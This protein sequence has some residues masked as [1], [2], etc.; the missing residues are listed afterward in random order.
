MSLSPA[1]LI[2]ALHAVPPELLLLLQA[3]I[4]FGAI[5]LMARLFGEPGLYLYIL[6][7]VIGANVEVLK[8]VQ[9]GFYDHPVAMGTVLFGSTYLATDI[10]TEHYGRQA[11]RRAVFL[12]FAGYLLF[13]G[14]MLLTLGFRPMTAAQAGTD[15]QWALPMQEH[16]AALF[17]P[18]PALFAAGM[19]SYL[20]SQLFDVWVYQRIRGITGQKHLWLR[21]NGSTMLSSFVDNC[22]FSV[23]AWVVFAPEPVGW[24]ALLHTYILGTYLLRVALSLLDTPFM[25]L[26]R[27]ALAPHLPDRAA[28]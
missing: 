24:D 18:A 6:I 10:L 5:L 20:I 16:I 13:T 3:L 11:A 21:N 25:Y 2:E 28:A 7:A 22:L 8:A 23:L 12:S 15:M 17:T 26:S 27:R 19:T 9:F 14:L 1:A 4:C